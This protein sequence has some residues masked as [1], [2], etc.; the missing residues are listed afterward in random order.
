MLREIP[1]PEVCE[2]PSQVEEIPF[3][4]NGILDFASR[5]PDEKAAREYME[6]IRWPDVV[7]C[8]RCGGTRCT[9]YKNEYLCPACRYKFTVQTG[10]FLHAQR[11]DLRTWLFYIFIWVTRTQN[12]GSHQLSRDVNV[13]PDTA[14]KMRRILSRA[15]FQVHERFSGTVEMDECFMTRNR[16]IKW[17]EL[18]N[19]KLPIMGIAERGTGR[20]VIQVVERR[21]FATV[22]AL[23]KKHVEPGCKVYTDGHACYQH[24]NK[25][26]YDHASVNHTAYE[27]VRG[28]VHTNTIENVWSHF[29]KS[30]RSGHQHIWAKYLQLYCDEFSFRWNNRQLNSSEL[31]RAVLMRVLSNPEDVQAGNTTKPFIANA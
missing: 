17:A 29:K 24:L 13:T 30:I 26:G 1:T 21:D 9:P 5:F 19:S 11:T 2:R 25:W 18:S 7:A 4:P 6:S 3:I 31:F 28:D 22:D 27:Y 12:A 20:A 16:N 8:C 15:L 10:T 14:L 23:L